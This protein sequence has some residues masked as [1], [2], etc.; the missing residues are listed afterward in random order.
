MRDF[1]TSAQ[2]LPVRKSLMSTALPYTLR[3]EAMAVF[4]AQSATIPN[5]LVSTV[6]MPVFSKINAAL[7]DQLDLAFTSGQAAAETAK[8][9]DEQVQGV[10]AA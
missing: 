4:V 10:L 1:V 7:T 2:F 3:P 9:I 6:T 8:A 5:H